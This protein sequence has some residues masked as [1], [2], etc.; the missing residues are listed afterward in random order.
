MS[1]EE[2]FVKSVK[3]LTL[4]YDGDISEDIIPTS[5]AVLVDPV[6]TSEPGTLPVEDGEV[7]A[8][9]T[10]PVEESR[11]GEAAVVVPLSGESS[12]QIQLLNEQV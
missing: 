9:E 6:Q 4:L 1:Q 11:S 7:N 10:V 2:S 12:E 3:A 8:E 5:T